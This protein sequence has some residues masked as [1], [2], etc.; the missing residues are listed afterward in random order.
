MP[1]KLSPSTQAHHISSGLIVMLPVPSLPTVPFSRCICPLSPWAQLTVTNSPGAPLK[2]CSAEVQHDHYAPKYNIII[3]RRAIDERIGQAQF[4]LR[5]LRIGS[6][7]S[8]HDPEGSE[9]SD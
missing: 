6:L 7:T 3:M 4:D 2:V 9:V 1:W 5:A 8:F